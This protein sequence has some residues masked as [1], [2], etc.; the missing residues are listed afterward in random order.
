ML[1]AYL[2]EGTPGEVED[3]ILTV[4]FNEEFDFH[5]EALETPAKQSFM[6]TLLTNKLGTPIKLKFVA[7]KAPLEE[8]GQEQEPPP[9]IGKKKSLIRNN[10]IIES[11]IDIFD[12][13]IEEVRE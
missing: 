6:E 8:R 5:R 7:R 11:A 10:P 3:G 4:F 9:S 2:M 12:A 13:S 1:K